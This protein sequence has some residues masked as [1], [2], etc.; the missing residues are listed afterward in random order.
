MTEPKSDAHQQ[1]PAATLFLGA[2]AVSAALAALSAIDE[3]LQAILASAALLLLLPFASVAAEFET[4]TRIPWIGTTILLPALHWCGQYTPFSPPVLTKHDWLD[5][6]MSAGRAIFLM[7]VLPLLIAA[8]RLRSCR[9]EMK[10][11]QRHDLDSLI[12]AQSHAWPLTGIVRS[13]SSIS[14]RTNPV[15]S[16]AELQASRTRS[17]YLE[18]MLVYPELPA[19]LPP[20]MEIALRPEVWLSSQRLACCPAEDGHPLDPAPKAIEVNEHLSADAVCEAM[21]GQLGDVWCGFDNLPIMLRAFT[22]GLAL[23]F[24]ERDAECEDMLATLS[25]LAEKAVW[26]G[27][28]LDD[29]ISRDKKTMR[30]IASILAGP[31][32]K[33]LCV[34]ADG[35]AFQRTAFMAMLL[36]A[37]RRKGVLASASFVWLKREDRVLW[38]ALNAAGNDAAAA[39]AAGVVAHYRAERQARQRLFLPRT[40]RAGCSLIHDYLDLD[41]ARARVRHLVREARKPVGDRLR[42]TAGNFPSC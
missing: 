37:R 18:G 12:D 38:Y 30:L 7:S 17:E 28:A 10:F 21:D 4:L 8:F 33:R 13:F 22:A 23:G 40:F 39:E 42:E 1:D 29:M 34:I 32:G 2:L 36:A 15:K 31:E 20:A 16:I 27:C 3:Q 35:H 6:Q 14:Q 9:P 26:Q 11:R 25:A 41:P 24:S 5:L 19:I